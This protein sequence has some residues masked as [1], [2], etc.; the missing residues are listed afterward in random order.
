MVSCS[1][2]NGAGGSTPS[3]EFDRSKAL[4]LVRIGHSSGDLL[5][6]RPQHC[7]GEHMDHREGSLAEDRMA[8]EGVGRRGSPHGPVRRALRWIIHFFSYH[9]VLSRQSIRTTRAAGF[10]LTVRPTVFHP[11]FFIS[12]E[13]FAGFLDGLDLSGKRVID[14]GT[15][16]G[17]LAL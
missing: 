11:R 16:T 5:G 14:V 13:A 7:R 1:M 8:V 6:D 9:L 4:I 17:V 12:S 10:R 2:E 3:L 15:G